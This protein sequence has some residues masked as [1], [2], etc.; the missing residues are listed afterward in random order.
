[1]FQKQLYRRAL[2]GESVVVFGVGH[3]SVRYQFSVQFSNSDDDLLNK[4]VPVSVPVSVPVG[5]AN[6]GKPIAAALE[7]FLCSWKSLIGAIL[8]CIVPGS[9]PPFQTC[10]HAVRVAANQGQYQ[11]RC[12]SSG[13]ACENRLC[14]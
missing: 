4:L 10:P 12:R 6:A 7:P 11:A 3:C 5:N 9:N 8:E 2:C 13:N 1:M 14:K